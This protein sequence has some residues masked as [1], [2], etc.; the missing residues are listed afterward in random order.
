VA[1][2]RLLRA[3]ILVKQEIHRTLSPKYFHIQLARTI[4]EADSN[5]PIII[6]LSSS[7]SVMAISMGNFSEVE[8]AIRA[9]VNSI[10]SMLD[11]P[12]GNKCYSK[13]SRQLY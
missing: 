3:A 5:S 12:Q 9:A 4:N 7:I 1:N 6:D 8:T 13:L 11:L 10:T 2:I